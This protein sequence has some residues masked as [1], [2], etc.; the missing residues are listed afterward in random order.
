[1]CRRCTPLPACL[2]AFHS[3]YQALHFLSQW[4]FCTR[5][6]QRLALTDCFLC[7][8]ILPCCRLPCQMA[9]C[10][11]A[12]THMP[13][14]PLL[15]S[16]PAGT[17]AIHQKPSVCVLQYNARGSDK[18]RGSQG[19]GNGHLKMRGQN[20]AAAAEGTRPAGAS[21]GCQKCGQRGGGVEQSINHRPAPASRCGRPPRGRTKCRGAPPLP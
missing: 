5:P 12:P 10:P 8:T 21:S 11:H 18:Y 19:Q 1:M 20:C 17:L 9:L 13:A 3:T 4:R 6:A 2:P 7:L 14:P 16:C 15:A